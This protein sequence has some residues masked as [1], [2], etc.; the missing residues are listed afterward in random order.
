MNRKANFEQ[1]DY[2]SEE[3]AE[4]RY[5]ET[6]KLYYSS[7]GDDTTSIEYSA[8][9]YRYVKRENTSYPEFYIYS[10][11]GRLMGISAPVTLNINGET[12][13]EMYPV[14]AYI[15]GGDRV[16]CQIDALADARYYYLYNG[17]GDVV[18]ITDKSG[19]IVQLIIP[20]HLKI[21]LNNYKKSN[22]FYAIQLLF[23]LIK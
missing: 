17:H 21:Y 10:P 13:V 20:R 19:N 15:W 9:G 22:C 18:A 1:I 14:K 8:N 3:N 4:Y 12:K 7:V 6:D 11:D 2:L 5:D 23:I 16:L